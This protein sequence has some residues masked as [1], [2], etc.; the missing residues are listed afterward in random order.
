[1]KKL[2]LGFLSFSLLISSCFAGTDVLYLRAVVP[3]LTTMST[4][5]EGARLVVSR[6][7]NSHKSL[8]TVWVSVEDEG[9]TTIFSLNQQASIQ[10]LLSFSPKRITFAQQ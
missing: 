7:N 6:R 1:M 8:A 3:E 4:D 10:H 9:E 2:A 5:I